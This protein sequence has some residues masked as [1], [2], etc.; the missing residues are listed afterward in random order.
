MKYHVTKNDSDV[1]KPAGCFSSAYRKGVLAIRVDGCYNT[2][3][4]RRALPAECLRALFEGH[5][6]ERTL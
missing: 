3:V 5:R 4:I 1:T 2:R 6:K